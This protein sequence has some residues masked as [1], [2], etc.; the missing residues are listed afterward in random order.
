MPGVDHV[1]RTDVLETPCDVLVP[2]AL[3]HQITA[4]NADRLDCQLIVEA[5]NGPTTPEADAIL[6]SRG[7]RRDPRRAGQR[8]RGDRELLRV[9]PG[10]AEVLLARRGGRSPGCACSC[11]R[12]WP[13]WSTRARSWPPTGAPPRSPWPSS[14]WP[15]RRGC[16]RSIR[17]APICWRRVISPSR[18]WKGAGLVL[19]TLCAAL[20]AA[21]SA[22]AA[23]VPPIAGHWEARFLGVPGTPLVSKWTFNPC[24]GCAAIALVMT[25]SRR[26]ASACAC[27]GAGGCG[28]P[29]TAAGRTAGTSS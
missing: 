9:G 16:A 27:A 18:P 23:A 13:G 19:A 6:A 4:D 12:R 25:R 1:G 21:P 29:P 15:R 5:A 2:A 22:S 8:R 7:D 3:E 10:P 11:P 14:G 17:E 26:V 20:C 24:R 28:W